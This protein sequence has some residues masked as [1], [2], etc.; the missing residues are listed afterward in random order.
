MY[1]EP[2]REFKIFGTNGHVQSARLV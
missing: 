1:I 2:G